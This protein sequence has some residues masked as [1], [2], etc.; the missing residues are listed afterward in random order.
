MAIA[1]H[2]SMMAQQARAASEGEGAK[3][4]R[5]Q[6][7]GSHRPDLYCPCGNTAI[8]F[9]PPFFDIVPPVPPVSAPLLRE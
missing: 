4:R 6:C 3:E 2:R 7:A 8:I 9:V 1:Q 5:R